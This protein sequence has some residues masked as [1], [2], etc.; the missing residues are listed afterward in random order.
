V[1]DLKHDGS[2]WESNDMSV[3]VPCRGAERRGAETHQLVGSPPE[4]FAMSILYVADFGHEE[5]IRFI[6]LGTKLLSLFGGWVGADAPN[7]AY[8]LWVGRVARW[9]RRGARGRRT[10]L[11]RSM[12][13]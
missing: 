1:P 8:P 10:P 3:Y 7:G 5:A 9:R 2:A 4:D 12:Y 6:G 11:L 13:A